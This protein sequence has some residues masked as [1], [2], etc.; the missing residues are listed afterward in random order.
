M[1]AKD[2]VMDDDREA[3]ILLDTARWGLS[4]GHN[5]YQIEKAQTQA[6][7]LAQA[8]ISFKAGYEKRDSEFVYNPD[9]LDFQKGVKTGRELG[10]MEV[11][12]KCFWYR[13]LKDYIVLRI[14]KA[15]LKE[16]DIEEK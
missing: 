3:Q 5:Q 16:W 4:A 13:E 11:V 12:D 9:Y 2:T 8:E 10:I 7:R 1:E 14:P 15:K 6:R